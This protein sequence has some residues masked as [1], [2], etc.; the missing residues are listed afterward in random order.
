MANRSAKDL[1]QRLAAQEAR[2]AEG[3]FLAPC[4]PGAKVRVRVAGMVRTYWPR[5][6]DMEGWGLFRAA[7]ASTAAFVE[8]PAL[9]EVAR[10]LEI[11]RP[12]RV[13][14]A[15]PL[16]G[17]AWL[18]YPVNESDW[19]QRI[20]EPRPAV[21]HLVDEGAPFE[22][23]L[24]RWDGG[25]FWFDQVDRRADPVEADSL[26]DSLRQIVLPEA[27]RR[28]GLTPEARTAYTIAAQQAPGFDA[29]RERH[30]RALRERRAGG[31]LEEA[32][33]TGGGSL[34]SHQ[35]RGDY[36]LVEWTDRAGVEH[37]SAIG[38][39]DLTVISS[40]ICLSG[41]DRDFDLASLVGVMADW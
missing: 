5:P 32:L 7:D 33:Q 17:R 16:R 31:R 25:A 6:S 14:L 21:V 36:W 39:Q 2:A 26:R 40:G 15:H 8:E 20:G 9:P 10:Y 37:T 29:L 38:K 12:V 13:R 22:V 1:I 18:A 30:D 19:R 27:L 23:A 24:V 11:L 3:L 34:R 28:K 35:D 4:V 41:Q